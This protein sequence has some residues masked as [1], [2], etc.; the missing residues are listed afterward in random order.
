MTTDHGPFQKTMLNLADPF[1][2]FIQALLFVSFVPSAGCSQPPA[3][4]VINPTERHQV[5]T[6]WEVTA[7]A[8]EFDKVNDRFDGSL[9]THR[10]QVASI[11]VDGAGIDRIRLEMKSGS[12]NPID[13]WALFE[14]GSIGY[15]E[16]KKHFYEKINDN[17]DPL[18]LN[19]AGIHFS[20]LDWHVENI[21]LPAKQ[22]IEARG[23]RFRLNL[24]YVDFR[25]T[26]AKGTMS[27]A[28]DSAEYAELIAATFVH[29]KS[30]YG[31]IPDSLEIIIE[32]DNSDDWDGT[33][34][35]KAIIA[36]ATRLDAAGFPNVEIIA[37]STA[38]AQ[39]ALS[40]FADIQR[41]PGAV[42]RMSTLSYHRY[43]GAPGASDL[44]A[45]RSA[46]QSANKTTAMLEYVDG[47]IDDL[48]ADLSRGNASAWQQYGIATKPAKD[49]PVR[50]GWLIVAQDTG[51]PNASLS[52]TTTARKL[53]LLFNAVDQGS[54][55]IGTKG[56]DARMP[57]VGFITST[58]KLVI[59]VN[60][61]T[62]GML[63][64]NGLRRGRYRVTQVGIDSSD[65]APREI[66]IDR[67]LNLPTEENTTY[68][69]VEL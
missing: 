32:P 17:A 22:K 13:Y 59:V 26:E 20:D 25:W 36:A 50:P 48:I 34:I 5:I 65:P 3:T 39:R 35:G 54:I 52:L 57:A 46:A 4:L 16:Y 45:I 9:A 42:R 44:Q 31:L 67:F 41:V 18:T 1:R 21:V 64:I 19:P 62:N 8:W 58:Q 29:L 37:P 24:A 14:A 30:K 10:D 56:N 38:K 7:R 68:A 2:L 33:A 27:H 49:K 55:R 12:E 63:K 28:N 15:L 69:L 43:E 40:Y 23:R 61:R 53:A 60:A 11:L 66:I 47:G 6:G 51:S